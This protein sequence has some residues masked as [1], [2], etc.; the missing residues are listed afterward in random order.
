MDTRKT[1]FEAAS[2]AAAI[3]TTS[4][5]FAGIFGATATILLTTLDDCVWLVPYLASSSLPLNIRIQHATIFAFTLIGLTSSIVAITHIFQHNLSSVAFVKN[6]ETYETFIETFGVML[7]WALAGYYYYKSWKKRQ[8]R[9]LRQKEQQNQ[10]NDEEKSS[11]VSSSQVN[12]QNNVTVNNDVGNTNVEST[13]KMATT[14]GS[15]IGD[16]TNGTSNGVL[17][18]DPLTTVTTASKDHPDD[19]QDDK[20]HPSLVQPW[21]IITLT[22]S[23]A[24]DEISYFPSLLLGH[25]F[26][27]TELIVGTV[28]TVLIM[29]C[30]VTQLLQYCQPLLHCL[31][32]IPLYGIIT[33]YAIL[34]TVNLILDLLSSSK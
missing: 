4:T 20:V 30:I 24:L 6:E 15:S 23:G 18:V 26:T 10:Q 11:L 9:M 21:T 34:L 12:K 28:I 7:C 2:T 1:V 8:R 31:D 19:H 32:Q 29:L 17:F 25:I 27:G 33:L 5:T 3:S 13:E 14:Y 22:I 16:D